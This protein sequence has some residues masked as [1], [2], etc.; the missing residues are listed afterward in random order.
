MAFTIFTTIGFRQ[1]CVQV[2]FFLFVCVCVC[3]CVKS[4]DYSDR[5]GVSSDRESIR[6]TR[7][8][9]TECHHYTQLDF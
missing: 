5:S 2:H 8:P 6:E 1:L 9:A 7:Q 3:V 4:E